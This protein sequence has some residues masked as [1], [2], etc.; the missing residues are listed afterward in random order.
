MVTELILCRNDIFI[1]AYD[2]QVHFKFR[3][4][5][6]LRLFFIVPENKC[7]FNYERN[8]VKNVCI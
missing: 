1:S 8:T 2:G 3:N 4:E 5:D 6:L 7:N